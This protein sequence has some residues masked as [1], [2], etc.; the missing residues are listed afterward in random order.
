[1]S[2]EDKY[3]EEKAIQEGLTTPAEIGIQTMDHRPFEE[4]LTDMVAACKDGWIPGH[5]AMGALKIMEKA[6]E[7]AKAE[8]KDEAVT[9]MRSYPNGFENELVKMEMRA[10]ATRYDYKHIPEWAKLKEQMKAIEEG[11]KTAYRMYLKGL[12]AFD[13]ET[14]E[15]LTPAKASG[16]AETVFITLKKK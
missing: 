2:Q 16:G 7:K 10:T 3:Y 15:V 6:I 4:Q 9:A 13:H 12:E 1:M 14:G 11:A 8:L 5:E